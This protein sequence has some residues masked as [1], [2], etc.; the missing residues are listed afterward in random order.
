[1]SCVV[2]V[3]GETPISKPK[4]QFRCISF[5]QMAKKKKKKKKKKSFQS[6]TIFSCQAAFTP[7]FSTFLSFSS[8][9]LVSSYTLQFIAAHGQSDVHPSVP[10]WPI[11]V[12][13][14]PHY[15]AR[16][17]SGGPPPLFFL[18][19][20]AV[21]HTYHDMGSVPPPPGVWL[22]IVSIVCL[23]RVLLENDGFPLFFLKQMVYG[24]ISPIM[25]V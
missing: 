5:S 3:A 22:Y 4:F 21:A 13:K 23:M 19:Y 6:I 2:C 9:Q 10:E 25:V 20:F 11:L 15:H 7:S 24:A 8:V 18:N 1:M 17:S 12:P 14:D 16:A